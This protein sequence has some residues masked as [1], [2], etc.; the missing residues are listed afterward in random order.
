VNQA[1]I[2]R[3]RGG[4]AGQ[5]LAVKQTAV[6]Y[7]AADGVRQAGAVVLAAE[8]LLFIITWKNGDY[9]AY[10]SGAAKSMVIK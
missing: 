5:A 10:R 6:V 3:W 7:A 2:T 8:G 9:D 1:A 4:A